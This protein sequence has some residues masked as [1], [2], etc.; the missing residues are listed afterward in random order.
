MNATH[1]QEPRSLQSEERP[2]RWQTREGCSDTLAQDS[3]DRISTARATNLALPNIAIFEFCQATVV[4]IEVQICTFG[5]GSD[6]LIGPN[7]GFK[8]ID[9]FIQKSCRV[10]RLFFRVRA[11]R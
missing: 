5:P 11:D 10:C 2:D 7:D 8:I 3:L 6:F 1:S 4:R 9:D